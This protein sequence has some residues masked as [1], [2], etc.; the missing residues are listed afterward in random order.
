MIIPI[1]R[2]ERTSNEI[3]GRGKC[4]GATKAENIIRGKMT[5]D[6]KGETEI[7]RDR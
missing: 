7:E 4:I 1:P 5:T 3:R 2:E 6:W